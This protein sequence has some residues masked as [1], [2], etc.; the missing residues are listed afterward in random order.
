MVEGACVFF[1]IF[2]K[3]C[4]LLYFD[5]FVCEK[6][7]DLV[8]ACCEGPYELRTFYTCFLFLHYSR[9]NQFYHNNNL[10][11]QQKHDE[12]IIAAQ[13]SSPVTLPAFRWQPRCA[14]AVSK[15][16]HSH[17]LEALKYIF[18]RAS[19]GGNTFF[20][21]SSTMRFWS[22]WYLIFA[23]AISSLARPHVS[24]RDKAFSFLLFQSSSVREIFFLFL[25]LSCPFSTF[26]MA[27]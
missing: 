5:I 16:V 4:F 26:S 17:R 8:V 25:T 12:L 7:V 6:K 10:N 22:R 23:F 1:F 21:R 24:H 11:S 2:S 19:K 9:I 18:K 14:T 15:G 13:H 20:S 3:L 27:R